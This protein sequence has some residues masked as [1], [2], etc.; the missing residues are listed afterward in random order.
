MNLF[1][2]LLEIG[3]PLREILRQI[4]TATGWRAVCYEIYCQFAQYLNTDWTLSIWIGQIGRIVHYV[5]VSIPRLRLAE[6][7]AFPCWIDGQ[8]PPRS[9]PENRACM[10]STYEL[11]S[12]GVAVSKSRS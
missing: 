9:R 5:C 6:I 10:E 12:L 2:A 8:E 11:L 1:R 3:F 7:R 4:S